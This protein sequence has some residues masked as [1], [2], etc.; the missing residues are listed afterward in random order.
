[1][2]V[3]REGKWEKWGRRMKVATRNVGMCLALATVGC[4]MLFGPSGLLWGENGRPIFVRR[5]DTQSPA[6]AGGTPES[7]KATGTQEAKPKEA[8]TS[9]KADDK[10]GKSAGPVETK[11]VGT[12]ESLRKHPLPEWYADA[13]LGIF[14]HWG[15]YSVPGWAVP[16]PSNA[17]LSEEEY[18]KNNPYAEW[19]LNTLR[20]EGS[21]TQKYHKQ[22]YGP[23]YDYYNFADTFNKEIQRWNPDAWARVFELTGAKYVVLTTKHHD[24]FTLWPSEIPNPTLPANRQHASRDL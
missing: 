11:Y 10:S 2:P 18:L 13:K 16:T 9:A 4:G 1:M 12:V 24:G 17:G 20:L 21:P 19:Y 23:N 3:T 14:I 15:L 5:V 6:N 7:Q 8:A 22:N